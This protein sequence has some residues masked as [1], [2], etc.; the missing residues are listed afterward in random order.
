M[1]QAELDSQYYVVPPWASWFDWR[2]VSIGLAPSRGP[3]SVHSDSHSGTELE[4]E[5]GPFGGGIVRVGWPAFST[6]PGL[7][8]FGMCNM[9][10]PRGITV[11]HEESIF[12]KVKYLEKVPSWGFLSGDRDDPDP[13]SVTIE[14]A[15]ASSDAVYW[16][17]ECG[18]RCNINRVQEV[19]VNCVSHWGGNAVSIICPSKQ[20]ESFCSENWSIPPSGAWHWFRIEG[21]DNLIGRQ[22]S[23]VVYAS[24]AVAWPKSMRVRSIHLLGA[25]EG[26]PEFRKRFWSSP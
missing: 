15:G 24:T 7:N 16:L 6:W 20:V 1:L 10:V 13:V 8:A 18:S 2:K 17:L 22:L 11:G 19:I 9:L 3:W 4:F 14:H 5:P 12:A 26:E 25:V 21:V 23:I